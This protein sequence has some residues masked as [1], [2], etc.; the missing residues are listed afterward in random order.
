LPRFSPARLLGKN[1]V[2]RSVVWSSPVPFQQ[3]GC[4]VFVD[5]NRFLGDF[6]LTSSHVL[7]HNRSAYIDL[8]VQKVDVFPFQTCQLTAAQSR[9]HVEKNQTRSRKRTAEIIFCIAQ[10]Q[11]GELI[12]PS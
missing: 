7:F 1:P 2:A 10:A 9:H 6:G 11:K 3:V 5:G 8:Q 12:K 4:D